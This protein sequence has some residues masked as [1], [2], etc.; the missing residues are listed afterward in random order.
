MR[1]VTAYEAESDDHTDRVSVY[2]ENDSDDACTHRAARP[3]PSCAALLP[4]S[5]ARAAD[6]GPDPLQV[7]VLGWCRNS[8]WMDGLQWQL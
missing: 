1:K 5:R 8:L 4:T 7:P 2:S 6:P 3:L